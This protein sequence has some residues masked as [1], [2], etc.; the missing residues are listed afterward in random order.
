VALRDGDGNLRVIT[1]SASPVGDI[2]ARRE[3]SI[4]GGITEIAMLGTPHAGSNLTTVVRDANGDLL[5]V[6]WSIDDNG[7]NL[8][9]LGSAKAGAVT[10]LTADGISRSY[11]GHDSRDM[12]LTAVKDS[13]GNLKL[14]TWDTNLNNP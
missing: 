8:R 14:V 4:A 11:P 1:W 3:T 6:G 5:L 13:D 12:I 9:R 7:T 10:H 2:G